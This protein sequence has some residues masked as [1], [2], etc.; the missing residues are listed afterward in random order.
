MNI[1]LI[2]S[3]FPFEKS[4]GIVLILIE[5]F[6]AWHYYATFSSLSFD[7]EA[8]ARLNPFFAKS[9]AKHLPKPSDE[10]VIKTQDPSP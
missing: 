4:I 1:Y 5:G 3:G 8:R 6:K 9:K 7:R 2:S 10:P